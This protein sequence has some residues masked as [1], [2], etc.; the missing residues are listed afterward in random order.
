MAKRGIKVCLI[1]HK[2]M[3]RAHSNAYLKADKFFD[4]PVR[5]IMQTVCGRDREGLTQFAEKWGWAKSTTDWRSAIA[6][7]QIDLVDVTAPN[8]AHLEMSLA[9]LEA[10][11]DLA[12]EKP[13]AGTLAE[14]RQMRDAARKSKG[15]TFV[16]WSYRRTPA[17]ALAHQLVKA[18]KIGRV[19]MCR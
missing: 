13:L 10:G 5:P 12:C 14:A 8:N 17:V 11:K 3:G 16:W 19:P 2:F 6:D 7:P 4:L 1:G 9:A 18:G 15:K